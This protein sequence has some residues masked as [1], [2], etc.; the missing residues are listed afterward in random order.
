MCFLTLFKKKTV[1][2]L[3]HP[4]EKPDYTRTL[5]NTNIADVLGQWSID[6]G[7]PMEYRDFWKSKIEI[8]VDPDFGY[9][10]NGVAYNPPCP[11]GTFELD[12][13][14]HLTIRPE[15]CNP[16][17]IAHEQ[18]HNS[19]ALLTDKEKYE[20]SN[21]YN[22]L[23]TTDPLIKLLYSKNNYG[24]SNDIEGHAECYR[25]LGQQLPEAMKRFYPKLFRR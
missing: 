15:S 8:K 5:E 14:R 2:T 4:E 9:V 7:V 23:K 24:L 20:F 18:A 10:V 21:V 3:P 6:Y 22:P 16:G 17:V 25:F 19:Y 12:G 11:A 1:L 13:V